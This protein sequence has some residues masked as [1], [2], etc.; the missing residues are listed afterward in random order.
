MLKIA[1]IGLCL[2]SM[3][4]PAVAS[5]VLGMCL[6][7]PPMTARQEPVVPYIVTRSSRL[8]TEVI[9]DWDKKGYEAMGCTIKPPSIHS[10]DHW[11]IAIDNSLSPEAFDCTLIYEKAHLPPNSWGDPK[12]E[13]A[14]IMRRYHLTYY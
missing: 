6:D 2:C 11:Y 12:V 5:D 7:M 3:V 9:C 10:K 1:L 8:A 4:S 14:S 13:S